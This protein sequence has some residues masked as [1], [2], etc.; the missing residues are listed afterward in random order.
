[1]SRATDP[2]LDRIKAEFSAN[3]LHRCM[4]VTSVVE[5]EITELVLNAKRAN[6][7]EY[8]CRDIFSGMAIDQFRKAK[9]DFL[10]LILDV[11]E[12]CRDSV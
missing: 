9:D 6:D 2:A 5:S 3:N 7:V 10:W 12:Q 11:P 8:L 1:M 4:V